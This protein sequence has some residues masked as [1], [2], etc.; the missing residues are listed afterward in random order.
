VLGAAPLAACV[1]KKRWRI[2]ARQ[3]LPPL[4]PGEHLLGPFAWTPERA[5]TRCSLLARLDSSEDPSP[6]SMPAGPTEN[7]NVAQ[8]NLCQVTLAP[9]GTCELDFEVGEG[10]AMRMVSLRWDIEY[11]DL[12]A[13]S[14]VGTV[15]A[16][17]VNPS[18]NQAANDPSAAASTGG[19]IGALLGLDR[20]RRAHLSLTLSAR[21]QPGSA[22]RLVV[23]QRR[24]GKVEGRVTFQVQV[25]TRD[26]S[27]QTD[28]PLL[29]R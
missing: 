27:P 16:V 1:N 11:H 5:L 12:P 4:G 20:V 8:R 9:G 23:A 29:A 28:T 25:R 21:A 10:L 3:A 18:P 2:I 19:F 7:D 13:G 26:D 6:T 24:Y 14:V 17:A 15:R 22:H